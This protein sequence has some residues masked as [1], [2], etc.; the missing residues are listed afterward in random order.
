MCKWLTLFALCSAGCSQEFTGEI[1]GQIGSYAFDEVGAVWHGGP[2][3]VLFDR[4]VDCLDV[5]WVEQNY[6]EGISPSE[7]LDYV[8]VQFAF[9]DGEPSVGTFSVYGDAAAGAMGLINDGNYFELMQGRDGTITISEV[10]E[11]SVIGEFD[12]SF[13]TGALTG[14]FESLYCRNLK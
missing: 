2:F 10:T 7:G 9:D 8:A 4:P 3:I 1:A 14:N 5:Y 12:I 13:D 11:D 6:F